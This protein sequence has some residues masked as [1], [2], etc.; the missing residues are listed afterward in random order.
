MHS[1]TFRISGL[2]RLENHKK[3]HTCYTLSALVR[4]SDTWRFLRTA[5]N[6]GCSVS[7]L[8]S[9][10]QARLPLLDFPVSYE[11]ESELSFPLFYLQIFF[12]SLDA[13]NIRPHF[14]IEMS[15]KE[16]IDMTSTLELSL[17]YLGA[18]EYTSLFSCTKTCL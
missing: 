14:V 10:S 1:Q 17:Q 4:D 6:M 9:L 3:Y 16:H 11:K 15:H 8:W 12:E 18:G 2:L 5:P 13:K 7:Y